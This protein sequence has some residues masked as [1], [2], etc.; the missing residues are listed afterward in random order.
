MDCY[1]YL[2]F[3]LH[4]YYKKK[5]ESPV[6]STLVIVTLFVFLNL[7]SIIMTYEFITDFWT[8]PKLHPNYKFNT[9]AFLFLFSVFN[10]FILY[11][12]QKYV[13]IFNRFEK[14]KDKYKHWDIAVKIYIIF[15]ITMCLLVLIIAD[16]RNHNFELYFLK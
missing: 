6:V 11:R 10:Y 8:V 4:R 12:K 2:N 15:T 16:L 1:Y 13:S 3:F 14:N 7:F 9:I 5:R